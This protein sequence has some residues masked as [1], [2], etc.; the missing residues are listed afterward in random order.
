M[1]NT[2]NFCCFCGADTRVMERPV[3]SHKYKGS[4]CTMKCFNLKI[5]ADE[6]KQPGENKD[7]ISTKN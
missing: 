4:F 5:A 1:R 6:K 2:K 3:K 7:E